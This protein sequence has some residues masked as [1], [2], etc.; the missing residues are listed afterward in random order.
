MRNTYLQFFLFS[1]FLVFFV[2][3]MNSPKINEELIAEN[4]SKISII[5]K[6]ELK[7]NQMSKQFI[8][9]VLKLDLVSRENDQNITYTATGFSIYF[10]NKTNTSYILTNEHFCK[11][12]SPEFGG[13]FYEL[14]NT[15]MSLTTRLFSGE[16]KYIDSDPEKDLCLLS[17]DGFI[18]PVKLPKKEYQVS[19]MEPVLIVGSPEEIFPIIR[20]TYISNTV[21]ISSIRPDLKL[22]QPALLIS[23][24]VFHGESGS[25]VF[26]KQGEVIGIVTLTVMDKEALRFGGMAIPFQNFY[27]ILNKNNISY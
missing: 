2:S 11:P 14:G 12:Y 4:V 26:N 27:P 5:K 19:Q 6:N 24:L 8:D 20:D 13:F 22:T 9:P 10:D 17:L 7:S 18:Q 1:I 16:L 15:E 21:D 25:P 3:G 23:D